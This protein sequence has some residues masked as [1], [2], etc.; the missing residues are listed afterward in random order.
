MVSGLN[1]LIGILVLRLVEGALK[2]TPELALIHH[3]QMEA[4]TVAKMTLKHKIAMKT[5]VSLVTN[6]FKSLKIRICSLM[7]LTS[8][9]CNICLNSL[10]TIFT[11][12]KFPAI[13]FILKIEILKLL[14]FEASDAIISQLSK[15]C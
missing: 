9:V 12:S 8:E 11:S 13:I 3:L 15:M 14:K 4:M 10:Y 5:H 2:H 6:C 1:G 7:Q